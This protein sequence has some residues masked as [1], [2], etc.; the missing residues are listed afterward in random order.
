MTPRALLGAMALVQIVWLAILWWSGTAARPEKIFPLICY[1]LVAAVVV[2][3]C[4]PHIL[5]KLKEYL[6]FS[7]QHM[8]PLLVLYCLVAVCLSGL[9]AYLHHGWPDEPYVF[10]AAKIVAGQ[11]LGLFFRDYAEIPWLGKQHPPLVIVLYGFAL[12][13][14]A[15]DLLVLRIISVFFGLATLI[16]TYRI[17]K[18]LYTPTVG[19]LAAFFFFCMPFF[20][21][22]STAALTDMPVTCC[23]VLAVYL[24]LR[25]VEQPHWGRAVGVGVSVGVG[26]LSK[27]TMIVV[28]P[29]ILLTFF[30]RGKFGRAIPL[31]LVVFAVSVGM[32]ALWLGYSM[33]AGISG[34]QHAV[35]STYALHVMT[36]TEG[37]LW[38]LKVL[39]LRLPSGVGVAL[40]PL[41]IIGVWHCVERRQWTDMFILG[42]V[43]AVVV[44]LVLTLPGPRYFFPAFPALAFL[45]AC[46]IE[47][48]GAKGE[49]IVVL[50][51]LYVGSTFYLFVDWPRAAGALF[52]H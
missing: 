50:A 28:Y 11:G 43:I 30:L 27:Y 23:F 10:A 20:L 29:V 40:I 48:L 37:K 45:M 15:A 1:S 25:L 8:Q 42:W 2:D 7:S 5:A 33:R 51:G 49:R 39:L 46:T 36:T 3:R 17:G 38:L 14:L 24:T 13:L 12:R 26:L 18:I 4:P 52:A 22:L 34:A 41:L 21:R 9:Y 32:L 47:Q 35:L 19:V 31:L 16:L 44:P 6:R